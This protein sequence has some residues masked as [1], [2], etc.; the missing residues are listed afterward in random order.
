VPARHGTSSDASRHDYTY[1]LI[2]TFRS[3]LANCTVLLA[4]MGL[5]ATFRSRGKAGTIADM[6]ED[7]RRDWIPYVVATVIAAAIAKGVW[8]SGILFGG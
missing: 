6:N 8:Q 2:A 1:P 7:M 3:Q 5:V 4:F